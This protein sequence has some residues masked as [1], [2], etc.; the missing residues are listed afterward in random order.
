MNRRPFLHRCGFGLLRVLRFRLGGSLALRGDDDFDSAFDELEE[1]LGLGGIVVDIK[2]FAGERL[3]DRLDPGRLVQVERFHFALGFVIV[4]RLEFERGIFRRAD[5]IFRADFSPRLVI[6]GKF[7]PDRAALFDAHRVAGQVAGFRV[8]RVQ[9]ALKLDSPPFD[10]VDEF[11]QLLQ[12]FEHGH[13]LLAAKFF[14]VFQPQQRGVTG[15]ELDEDLAHL[16]IIFDV[17]LALLALDLVERR[18]GNINVPPLDQLRHLAVEKCQ[19]QGA[20]VRSVHV[21]VGHDHDPMIAELL[22]LKGVFPVH[23]PEPGA[24]RGDHV[25]DFVIIEHLIEARFFDIEQFAANRE[26]RLELPVPALLGRATGGITFDD[27]QFAHF[28]ILLRTIRE[29]PG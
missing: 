3:D 5:I 7:K 1:R 22:D 18:L 6:A 24:D 10:G 29:L 28:R 26:H 13:Q 12:G 2:T 17:F 20:D 21:S 27:V 11:L 16:I 19:Q 15:P 25:A 8:A 14:F 9:V 4:D 23:R